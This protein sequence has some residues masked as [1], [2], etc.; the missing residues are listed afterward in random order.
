VY[1]DNWLVPDPKDLV[2]ISQS[3]R[4]ASDVEKKEAMLVSKLFGWLGNQPSRVLPLTPLTF[5]RA[6]LAVCRTTLSRLEISLEF[7]ERPLPSLVHQLEII[8]CD[9]SL[10]RFCSSELILALLQFNFQS[11]CM[12][13]PRLTEVLKRIIFELRTYCVIRDQRFN[14]VYQEV[15]VVLE[16]YYQDHV[17][18]Y[19]QKLT[20]KI[21]HRTMR[22]VDR[23]KFRSALPEISEE[24]L[25]RSSLLGDLECSLESDSGDVPDSDIEGAHSSGS[26]MENSDVEIQEPKSW[27]RIVSGS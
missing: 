10:L 7:E 21:S 20:W 19:R 13:N 24:A 26:E 2:R 1:G 14:R 8:S 25:P 22:Y 12:N 5:L 15:A 16:K 11:M 17:S 6:M 3:K 23:P 4:S 27:A 18:P 9:S